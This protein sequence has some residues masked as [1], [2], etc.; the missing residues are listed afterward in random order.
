MWGI[1]MSHEFISLNWAYLGWVLAK[2]CGKLHTEAIGLCIGWKFKSLINHHRQFKEL[3]FNLLNSLR[4]T[5]I[6]NKFAFV[7]SNASQTY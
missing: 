3:Y 2:L 1:C 7:K 4:S 6:D 5:A